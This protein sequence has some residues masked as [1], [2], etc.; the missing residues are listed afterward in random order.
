M[1]ELNER[2]VG[3]RNEYM[4]MSWKVYNMKNLMNYYTFPYS[5]ETLLNKYNLKYT[6]VYGKLLLYNDESYESVYTLTDSHISQSNRWNH[7]NMTINL[8]QN[9]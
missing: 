5:D 4:G 9:N 8:I 2:N 7:E 3:E 1:V 6:S